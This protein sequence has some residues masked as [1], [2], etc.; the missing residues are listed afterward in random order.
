MI[1]TLG[2]ILPNTFPGWAASAATMITYLFGLSEA[3]SPSS[4]RYCLIAIGLALTLSPVVYKT[5]E[6]VEMVLVVIIVVFLAVAIVIATNAVGLGG[7]RHG[8][9]LRAW[10]TC[11]GI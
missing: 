2:S 3:A 6:K 7:H 5:L 8:G 10:R 11:P 4:P 9:S 1:F